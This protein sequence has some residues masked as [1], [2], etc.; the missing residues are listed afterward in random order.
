MGRVVNLRAKVLMV[1]PGS[2]R[3][4]VLEWLVCDYINQCNKKCNLFGGRNLAEFL[5]DETELHKI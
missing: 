1:K 3:R 2:E 5:F 4:E